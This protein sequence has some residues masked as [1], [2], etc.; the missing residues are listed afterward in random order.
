MSIAEKPFV[1]GRS[2]LRTIYDAL[3]LN[4][5]FTHFMGDPQLPQPNPNLIHIPYERLYDREAWPQRDPSK[6]ARRD[7]H[8]GTCWL[9]TLRRYPTAY[10]RAALHAAVLGWART[11]AVVRVLPSSGWFWDL[12]YPGRIRFIFRRVRDL[13]G[14]LIRS[15]LMIVSYAWG[16][17]K[18]LNP[19][20]YL[21]N[22]KDPD[23]RTSAPPHPRPRARTPI[24]PNRIPRNHLQS[25]A[26]IDDPLNDPED[27][28]DTAAD[29]QSILED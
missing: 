17:V 5:R 21:P 18:H 27:Y 16:D 13:D 26:P 2:R 9:Y 11:V 28:P 4:Y 1:L 6:G 22:P 19:D 7:R 3:A 12:A 23:P 14:N 10:L 25:R 15:P 24:S 8:T 29:D 20:D